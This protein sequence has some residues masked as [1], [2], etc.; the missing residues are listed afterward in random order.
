M[1]DRYWVG[2]TADWDGTAGTKWSTTSG[3]AGGSAVP[4]TADT[5]FFD[6]ASGANTV[7]IGAGTATCSNLTMT[8]FT[9]TIAFGT[10]SIT[11]AGTGV[12][13]TG[14]TTF[15]VTGTPLILCS[16]SSATS[17]TITPT[18]TT[19]ANS[20]SF[21]ITAG[22]GTFNITASNAVKNLDFTGFTGGLAL[23]T[24]TI[25]GNLTLVSGMTLGSGTSVQTF[26]ATSG[27]QEI[28]SAGLTQGY[29]ITFAGTATY[30]LVDSL[31]MGATRT[32][33]LTSGTLDLNN[34]TLTTNAVAS[35]NSNTRSILFG[36]GNITIVGTS[37][38]LWN[39]STIT[40]FTLTGT[41]TV[42]LTDSGSGTR[43]INCGAGIAS[44]A[45]SFYIQAGTGTINFNT[46][47]SVYKT[48]DLTGFSGTFANSTIFVTGNFIVP[49]GATVTSANTINFINPSTQQIT[50]N[51]VLINLP[52]NV[53]RTST[54]TSA[55]G[56]GTT[57]TISFASVT[58]FPSVGES[59]NIRGVTPSGYNGTYTVTAS[60]STS[61]SY[62][63]DTTGAQTVAG[64]VE[65]TGN[66]QLVDDLTLGSTRTL[67]LTSGT[68][69]SNA[70]NVTVG[71]FSA[72]N[73]N[74]KTFTITN[75]TF[76]VAGGTT[77]TGFIFT[78]AGT[79][80]NVT[81][82][83]IVFTTSGNTV[84]YGGTTVAVTYPQVTMSGT[85]ILNIGFGQ[86]TSSITTLT[87]TVQ[88]CTISVST[89]SQLTV[90]NF[91]LN[92]TPG[93]PVTFNSN[94]PGTARTISKSSG[95]VNALYLNIQDSTATGGA[96][97][98]ALN[99]TNAGNNTGWTFI[100]LPSTPVIL[101]GVTISGG[102][103]IV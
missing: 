70:K 36:T 92:G 83:N 39:F 67:T 16:N 43:T 81:G 59:I 64:V 80:F 75:S 53:G 8:G 55:A 40:G 2:G 97:W 23:A 54:T 72:A 6:A 13:Y 91:N 41:P 50:T 100:T 22:T 35:S 88:P 58:I 96:T 68:F 30:R 76:T 11:C 32:M 60:T 37:A 51:G 61:V 84:Y 26:A 46:T 89:T 21:N 62:A 4:T 102:L 38:T 103:T 47:N 101:S 57:A 12:I 78:T 10:N 24:R 19:E 31:T 95:T 3:G 18:A 86:T 99:S 90:T 74:T 33:T 27:T 52:I 87:N 9:G 94:V 34:N 15:S 56:N 28:T 25:Y 45:V 65:M 73:S 48:I 14:D 29:P 5:V 79:T 66:V 98:N 42:N 17:R 63:N 1:A 44:Q 77:T 71:S 7:T 20:I 85:G 49:S 82:S 69:N 93:N